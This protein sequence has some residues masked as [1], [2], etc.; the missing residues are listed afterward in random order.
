MRWFA[1]RM[2]WPIDDNNVLV[3][4]NDSRYFQ[5]AANLYRGVHNRNLMAN[6]SIFPTGDGPEGGT[7]GLVRHYPV[8]RSIVEHD[9]TL[10]GMRQY[11]AIV[12]L[13]SDPAGKHACSQLT[14]A[15]SAYRENR[16]VFL[17][18]R[19]MPRHTRDHAELSRAIAKANEQ[20]KSIDCEIEDLLSLDLL[21]NF[22][23]ASTDPLR[24]PPRVVNGAHHF[25]F[26]KGIKPSLLRFAIDC[27]VLRDVQMLIDVLKSLRYYLGLDPDG[28]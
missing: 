21:E 14:S 3:E 20:W 26:S 2:S 18:Q 7:H 15:H 22:C 1:S 16:D 19:V 28:V 8:F 11:R 12:L 4:G 17:L 23:Q 10:D 27:A 25:E 9:T 24:R 5:L 6:L 13:D